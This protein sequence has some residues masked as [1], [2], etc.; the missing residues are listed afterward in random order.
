M[1]KAQIFNINT[2]IIEKLRETGNMSG[3]VNEVLSDYFNKTKSLKIQYIE[4]TTKAEKL[5]EEANN[6]KEIAAKNRERMVKEYE[7]GKK[8]EGQKVETYN[9]DNRHMQRVCFDRWEIE[10]KDIDPLFDL[11]Y[12]GYLSGKYANI[13]QFMEEKRINKKRPKDDGNQA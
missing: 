7:E 9:F 5:L 6:L 13:L 3:I 8:K 2:E 12:E 10:E 4:K 11:Y 1:K